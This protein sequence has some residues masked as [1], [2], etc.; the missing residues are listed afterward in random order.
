MNEFKAAEL[1]LEI[2]AV[3]LSPENPFTWSSGLRSPIYCDNRLLMGHPEGRKQIAAWF[4]E[5][6]RELDADVIAGTATAGIPHAAWAADQAELP[7]IYVRSSPKS[8]GRKNKIEGNLLEGA[9]VL[10]IE[11]LLSTGGSALKAADAVQAEGGIPVGIAAIFTYDLQM[12]HEQTKDRSY[13]VEALTSFS[14]LL[15][16]A[17]RKGLISEADADRLA[18][19]NTDPAGWSDAFTRS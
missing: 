11:D 7:M 9:K 1:L 4:A 8:H 12:L 16:A 19:W 13:P 15:K 10:V 2:E 5:K 3:V 6:A 14:V 17:E 18:S